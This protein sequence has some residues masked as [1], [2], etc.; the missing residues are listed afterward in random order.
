MNKIVAIIP[1]RSGSR[2]IANKNIRKFA[3]TTLIENKIKQL[4]DCD[5]IDCIVVATNDLH[6]KEICKDYEVLLMHREERFCDEKST[7]ANQMIAD[8]ASRIDTSFDI[9]VWAHCT[10]PFINSNI[11]NQ[12]IDYFLSSEPHYDSLVSVTP[13]QNHFWHRTKSGCVPLNYNPNSLSHPLASD[14]EPMYYQNG[15]I[16]IQRRKDMVSNSYF[17]GRNPVLFELDE[18]VSTDINNPL[19]MAI[20][21]SLSPHFINRVSIE[22]LEELYDNIT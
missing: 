6:I 1:A 2:R 21:K 18:Y 17:F 20:A 5:D 7:T 15:G 19:D 11:Y 4:Q 16:F 13:I 9:I 22:E 14:L 10:N 3:N 12:S 8:I